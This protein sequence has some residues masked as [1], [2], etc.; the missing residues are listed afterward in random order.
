MPATL[1]TH[2]QSISRCLFSCKTVA[3][4]RTGH[5]NS[6]RPALCCR[7]CISI[8]VFP[9]DRTC[10]ESCQ[11]LVPRKGRTKLRAGAKTKPGKLRVNSSGTADRYFTNPSENR[12]NAGSTKNALQSPKPRR[13]LLIRESKSSG[14]CHWNVF[15]AAAAGS[16]GCRAS[17]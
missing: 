3:H 9:Q 11:L 13:E 17:R 5:R 10:S 8:Q 14:P 4:G 7:T 2:T 16:W 12:T 1:S 6:C 15:P